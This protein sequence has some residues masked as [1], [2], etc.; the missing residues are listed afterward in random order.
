MKAKLRNILNGT[1]EIER[2]G[3]VVFS[4]RPGS[5]ASISFKW[6]Y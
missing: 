1:I 6:E 5:S 3:V 2:E 4:E